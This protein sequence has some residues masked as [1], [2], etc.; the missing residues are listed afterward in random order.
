MPFD[1][2]DAGRAIDGPHVWHTRY[3]MPIAAFALLGVFTLVSIASGVL[4][5]RFVGPHAGWAALLPTIGAFG[6]LYVV[7]HLLDWTLGPTVE[8]FGFTVA[9]PWD[10]LLALLAAF[11]IASIQRRVRAARPMR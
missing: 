6:A 9:L 5:W 11:G 8:L 3:L 1:C 4:A 10:V 7:G 2:T